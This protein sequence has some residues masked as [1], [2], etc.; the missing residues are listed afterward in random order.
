MTASET[1]AVNRHRYGYFLVALVATLL[2]AAML[3]RFETLEWARSSINLIMIFVGVWAVRSRSVWF[4][5]L[6][7]TAFLTCVLE[8]VKLFSDAPIWAAWSHVADIVFLVAITV[9]VFRDVI[10]ATRATANIIYGS[11]AIYFLFML[12]WSRAYAVIAWIF[13]ESFNLG[14]VT[15]TEGFGPDRYLGQFVYFS[16][17]TMTTLGY[18]D[19]TPVTTGVRMLSG[20]QAV[21]GQLYLAILVARLVGL[22]IAQARFQSER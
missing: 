15:A 6:V 5:V 18:G 13:P 12:I 16:F 17:V 14:A 19:I 3:A 20:F 21:F 2:S 7:G 8:V 1:T 9:Y 10:T 11:I 4:K 22:N